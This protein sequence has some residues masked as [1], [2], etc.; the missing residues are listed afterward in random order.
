MRHHLG[1]DEGDP[2]IEEP[3]APTKICDSFR[4]VAVRLRRY[5]EDVKEGRRLFEHLVEFVEG[6]MAEYRCKMSGEAQ[7]LDEFYSVRLKTVSV[8]PLLELSR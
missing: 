4:D 3:A 5:V 2:G 8:K 6:V 1:L 7:S